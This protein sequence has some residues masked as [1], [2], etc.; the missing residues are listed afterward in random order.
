MVKGIGFVDATAVFVLLCPLQ[1]EIEIAKRVGGQGRQAGERGFFIHQ[2]KVAGGA[3]L[4]AAGAA[5]Q[6]EGPGI[7]AAI[8]KAVCEAHIELRVGGNTVVSGLPVCT[9]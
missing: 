2:R 7:A 4:G 8:G 6:I 1:V 9:P 5:E 3:G